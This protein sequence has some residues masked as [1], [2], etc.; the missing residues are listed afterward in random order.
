MSL[1]E[2][3]VGIVRDN[4]DPE[5]RGR[6]IIEA[7]TIVS[8][9]SLP[10]AEP[11]F[12]FVDSEANAGT[13]WVPNPGAMVE[14]EIEGEP[15]SEFSGLMPKWRCSV[16]PLGTVPDEFQQNYPNRSGWKTKSGH[17]LYFDDTDG[18]RSFYYGH[19]SGTV[20]Q[21]TENGQ[22]QLTPADGQS[23]L[24]GG[25]A[26]QQLVRGNILYDFMLDMKSWA[27]SHLHDAGAIAA[28]SGGGT[29]IGLS[30]VPASAPL[31]TLVPNPS[32][33]VPTDLLSD[34]H[35]VK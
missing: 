10:W 24:V 12:H 16:Y 22:I 19:P 8:G 3:H 7:P 21:V 9:E 29:C 34:L 28:P 5:K 11:I 20:I 30:G 33:D 23:V 25:E 1:K 17:V 32:P 6:L 18:S 13:F 4:D 26:D 2:Y 35:K 14:V 31:P 27:D 15:E